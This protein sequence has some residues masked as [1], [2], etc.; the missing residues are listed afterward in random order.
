MPSSSVAKYFILANK[1]YWFCSSNSLPID[2]IT[3]LLIIA[4]APTFLYIWQQGAFAEPF[5]LISA[6]TKLFLKSANPTS[7]VTSK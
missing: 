3:N 1:L 4:E 2:L 5:K 7:L 6:S